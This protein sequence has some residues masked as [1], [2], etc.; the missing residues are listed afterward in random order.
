MAAAENNP[1]DKNGESN[2]ETVEPS[3]REPF[4]E[5]PEVEAHDQTIPELNQPEVVYY[6]ITYISETTY[7]FALHS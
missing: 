6:A 7:W 2:A 1:K 5:V 4:S 3:S